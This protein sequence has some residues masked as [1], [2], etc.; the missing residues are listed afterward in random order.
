MTCNT[1]KLTKSH[2]T[3]DQGCTYDELL[4]AAQADCPRCTLVLK[5]IKTGAA[6]IKVED[7]L[8]VVALS[9]GYVKIN[10]SGGEFSLEV[11]NQYGKSLPSTLLDEEGPRRS[12]SI[13]YR[14]MLK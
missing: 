9:D 7:I 14:I 1:C 3:A 8:Q 5:C 2:D 4:Q 13:R 11:F 10:W 12:F 6:Q